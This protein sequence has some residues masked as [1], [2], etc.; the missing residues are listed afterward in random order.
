MFIPDNAIDEK[1][2]PVDVGYSGSSKD[3][4]YYYRSL[5]PREEAAHVS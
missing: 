4:Y 1:L 2:F 3:H 5:G